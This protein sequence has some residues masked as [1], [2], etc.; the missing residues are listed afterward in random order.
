MHTIVGKKSTKNWDL[1]ELT[2]Q[3]ILNMMSKIR[4]YDGCWRCVKMPT[5]GSKTFKMLEFILWIDLLLSHI[6]HFVFRKN[7]LFRLRSDEVVW[8]QHH[9][10]PKFWP[11]ISHSENSVE[12]LLTKINFPDTSKESLTRG[13]VLNNILV[14]ALVVISVKLAFKSQIYI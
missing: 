3:Q 10:T 4:E 11:K 13:C 6:Q 1:S 5:F 2:L 12:N 14:K 8:P 7:A 9:G